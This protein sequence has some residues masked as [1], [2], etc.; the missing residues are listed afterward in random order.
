[1]AAVAGGVANPLA[2]GEGEDVA[3]DH[4]APAPRSAEQQHRDAVDSLRGH[5]MS[6][7]GSYLAFFL[8]VVTTGLNVFPIRWRLCGECRELCGHGCGGSERSCDRRQAAFLAFLRP[9]TTTPNATNASSAPGLEALG[10]ASWAAGELGYGR[11]GYSRHRGALPFDAGNWTNA[12][13]FGWA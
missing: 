9:N 7:Y 6:C 12:T 5:W 1:M 10:D 3:A 2:G 13:N 8:A 4:K 11:G